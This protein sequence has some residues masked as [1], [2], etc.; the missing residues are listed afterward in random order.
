MIQL[1]KHHSSSSNLSFCV[2]T[3]MCSRRFLTSIQPRIEQLWL[4]FWLL[5]NQKNFSPPKWI[6]QKFPQVPLKMIK[7]CWLPADR[8]DLWELSLGLHGSLGTGS[9]P[10]SS[11]SAHSCRVNGELSGQESSK[12]RGYPYDIPCIMRLYNGIIIIK[13]NYSNGFVAS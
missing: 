3:Y 4:I 10:R 11:L 7:I 8:A 1:T 6:I 9:D 2:S 5:A 13:H 12:V